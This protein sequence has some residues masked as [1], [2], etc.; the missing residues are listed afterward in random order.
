MT[1]RSSLFSFCLVSVGALT[2]GACSAIAPKQQQTKPDAAAAPVAEV[3]SAPLSQDALARLARL[4]QN[5][6]G[7]QTEMATAR[8]ALQKIDT[9][10]RHFR[11]LTLEL[12]RIN[13]QYDLAGTVPVTP[14]T[15][16]AAA[17]PQAAEKPVK[18]ET[19]KPPPV[20][21]K[22]PESAVKKSEAKEVP[23]AEQP[24]AVVHEVE[25]RSVRIGEQ[26]GGV[27][28]IVLDT[29]AP[30]R[31][32]YD[33]DNAEHILVIELPDTLWKAERSGAVSKSDVVASFAADGDPKSSR[34][35]V[36]LKQKAK[37]TTTARLAPS[38]ASGH[39]VYLDLRAE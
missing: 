13:Q 35:V 20:P 39:R 27:T 16:S 7:L 15:P 14:V 21:M 9:M 6:A 37:V 32:N 10:E 12:D 4:E 24:S 34:L 2:L 3:Q 5:V 29:T 17:E 31:I 38:G 19:T 8:P 11:S 23:K 36:Q 33:L 25:V 26:A 18:L 22:K 1:L 30:A 28:R